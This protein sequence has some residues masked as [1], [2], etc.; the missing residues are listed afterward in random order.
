MR[1][2]WK[3]TASGQDLTGKLA[4]R[5]LSLRVTDEAGVHADRLE[6]G[7]DNRAPSIEAPKVGTELNVAL[8]YADDL[9]ELG[10][11]YVDEV[12]VSGPPRT[13]QVRA[14]A[15]DFSKAIAS[16]NEESWHNTTLGKILKKIASRHKLRPTIP[17]ELAN[18]TIEHEDQIESDLQFL[19][20]IGIERGV[21]IA[22]KGGR[23]VASPMQ[24]N[25][26]VTGEALPVVK[27]VPSDVKSWQSTLATRGDYTGVR[28][29]WQNRKGAKKSRIEVGRSDK[30]LTMPHPFRTERQA[31]AAAESKLRALQRGTRALSIT[32]EGD[33]RLSAEH[34]FELEGFGDGTDG[35]WV[36]NRVE[37]SLTGGGLETS[38]EAEIVV[39]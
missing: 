8:G 16:P 28:A 24:P 17:P 38:V 32:L 14:S 1:P 9:V 21:F 3:I 34:R 13:M 23:L 4:T 27:L 19:V 11:Y 20:R 26:T 31:I 39:L 12:E 37:H 5:L 6:V 25:A 15:V 18:I 33:P 35:V 10:V 22:S 2:A 7:L 29:Y 36:G 30:T